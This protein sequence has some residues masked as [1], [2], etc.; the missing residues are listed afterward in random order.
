MERRTVFANMTFLKVKPEVD[1]FSH[2]M[3]KGQLRTFPLSYSGT[4][5][6][7]NCFIGNRRTF[8]LQLL[9][10]KVFVIYGR[11]ADMT[12]YRIRNPG[13]QFGWDFYVLPLLGDTIRL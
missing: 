10:R 1:D 13:T 8:F 7:S 4:S 5:V 3:S 9:G 2:D 12:S 6:V 11:N